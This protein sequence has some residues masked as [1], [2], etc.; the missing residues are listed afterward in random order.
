[1]PRDEIVGVERPEV[2][3]A[4]TRDDAEPDPVLVRGNGAGPELA[5]GLELVEARKPSDGESARTVI[6]FAIAGLVLLRTS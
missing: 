3:A 2:A 4:P 5:G 1:V 6:R